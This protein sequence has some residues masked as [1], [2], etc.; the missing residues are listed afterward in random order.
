MREAARYAHA[1]VRRTLRPSSS[2]YTP[3][4]CDAQRA[5]LPVAVVAMNSHDVRDRRQSDDTTDR[6]QTASSLYAPPI[7][8]GG[9]TN[10]VKA[11]TLGFI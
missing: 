10:S 4:A 9:I 5:L 8:G 1:P 7:R 2:P 6:R 11:H 3:Y